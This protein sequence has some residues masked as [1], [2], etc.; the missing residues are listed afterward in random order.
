MLY[1]VATRKYKGSKGDKDLSPEELIVD[2]RDYLDREKRA[3]KLTADKS[4]EI[5][6]SGLAPGLRG[7]DRREITAEEYPAWRDWH[8]ENFPDVPPSAPPAR[9]APAAPAKP[10]VYTAL[11]SP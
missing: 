8:V 10:V 2:I 1:A 7:K 4:N 5:L 6:S 11:A 3:G 9:L